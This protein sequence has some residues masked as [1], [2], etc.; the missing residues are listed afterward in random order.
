[1]KI[2]RTPFTLSFNNPGF[3]PHHSNLYDDNSGG[4]PFSIPETSEP[5]EVVK[6]PSSISERQVQNPETSVYE[7][8]CA[9]PL[10]LAK[11]KDGDF[12]SSAGNPIYESI[13]GHGSGNPKGPRAES[14]YGSLAKRKFHPGGDRNEEPLYAKPYKI[15]PRSPSG[16]NSPEAQNGNTYA[17]LGLG[18]VVQPSQDS[19]FEQPG[20]ASLAPFSRNIPGGNGKGVS[21]RKGISSQD[22]FWPQNTVHPQ[23]PESQNEKPV[24]PRKACFLGYPASRLADENC[25]KEQL[26]SKQKVRSTT[27]KDKETPVLHLPTEP[28]PEETII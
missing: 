7:Q 21:S 1:M 18:R 14:D 28:G 2:F 25:S 12:Q 6:L 17:Q 20:Y 13:N 23:N 9:N 5:Y 26:S 27:L 19:G 11:S 4:V 3:E 15:K 16:F 22:N 24:S 10:Y 8:E